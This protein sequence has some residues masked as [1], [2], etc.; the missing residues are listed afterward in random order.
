M[1]LQD[2]HYRMKSMS[3]WVACGFYD[4]DVTWSYEKGD[5]TCPLCQKH[6]TYKVDVEMEVSRIEEAIAPVGGG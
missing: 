1:S 5:V 6:Y 3:W 4:R 2:T